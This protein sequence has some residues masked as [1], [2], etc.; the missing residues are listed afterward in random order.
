M[1]WSDLSR[2]KKQVIVLS[3]LLA[4]GI[5]YGLFRFVLTPSLA[6]FREARTELGELQAKMRKAK[7]AIIGESKLKAEFKATSDA[8]L[9]W[10][11]ELI[12]SRENPLTW[13]TEYIYRTGRE[14]G[15]DIESVLEVSPGV[16]PW[17][18]S[19]KIDRKFVPYTVRLVTE[20]TFF[21]FLRF[22][23]TLEERNPYLSIAAFEISG[24]PA[25]PE[26]HRIACTVEWPIWKRGLGPQII[27][28][29]QS[30]GGSGVPGKRVRTRKMT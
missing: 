16:V 6:T 12:P 27:K 17:E 25:N 15:I 3:V 26:V 30:Q 2:E 18:R 28:R 11:R 23:R 20:C 10:S 4:F 13:C 9:R 19:E 21:D 5:L 1:N 29:P 24:K 22:V 7:L 8:L 14:V